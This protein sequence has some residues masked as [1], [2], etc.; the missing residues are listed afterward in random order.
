M[1]LDTSLKRPSQTIYP[2]LNFNPALTPTPE[3]VKYPDLEDQLENIKFGQNPNL[4]WLV[5]LC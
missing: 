4:L 5:V 1:K 2:S 3:K